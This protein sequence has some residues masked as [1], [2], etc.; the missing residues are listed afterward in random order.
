MF[1]FIWDGKP[2]KIRRDILIQNYNKGGFNMIDIEIFIWSL[3][4]SWIKC[5]A[6]FKSC[7]LLKHIYER[8]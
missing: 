2:D 8:N 6:Q 1:N 5:Q 7:S 3:K 4:I